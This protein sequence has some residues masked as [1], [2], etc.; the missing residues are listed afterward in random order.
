[1]CKVN[2]NIN[3]GQLENNFNETVRSFVSED[4]GYM[5]MKSVNGTPAYWK[6]FLYDVLAMVK[7]LGLPSFFVTLSC[8]DLRWD[9]L[10][11]IIARLNNINIQESEIDYF[12]KCEILNQNPVLT[13]RHFQFRV[14]TFFKEILLHKNSPLG[15]VTNYVIK[16]EFQMRG[17]PHVHC[18]IWVKD[19]PLLTQKTKDEYKAYVDSIVRADIPDEINEPEL[20]RF[21]NNLSIKYQSL[22]NSFTFKVMSQIQ[23]HSMSIQLW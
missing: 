10:I 17:S 13:A 22:P 1:M 5:F 15:I 23:K 18:F 2:G 8:A 20:Y 3:A 19:P 9:E 14:E 6:H 7:Q 16:A 21:I 12:R 4:K 11:I